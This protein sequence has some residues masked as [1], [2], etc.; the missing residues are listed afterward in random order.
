MLLGDAL[1]YRLRSFILRCRLVSEP[2]DFNDEVS[3]MHDPCNDR[4]GCEKR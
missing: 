2:G 3:I 4:Q 1:T